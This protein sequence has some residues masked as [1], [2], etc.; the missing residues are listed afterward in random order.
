M[1]LW[2]ASLHIV[3]LI[4]S[5]NHIARGCEV[6][7]ALVNEDGTLGTLGVP[8]KQCSA[9]ATALTTFFK[10]GAELA[11]F[12]LPEAEFTCTEQNSTR[13][14]ACVG[15]VEQGDVEPMADYFWQ[16]GAMF[17]KAVGNMLGLGPVPCQDVGCVAEKHIRVYSPCLAPLDEHTRYPLVPDCPSV[18]PCPSPSPSPTSSP[19]PAPDQRPPQQVQ[20]QPAPAAS[21]SSTQPTGQQPAGQQSAAGS[22][23]PAA[24]KPSTADGSGGVPQPGQGPQGQGQASSGMGA[25]S[26]VGA[27][28]QGTVPPPSG[29]SSKK[30][31][32]QRKHASPPPRKIRTGIR[33]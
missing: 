5:L 16:T 31:P 7:V 22:P 18:G 27:Q 9:L 26:G 11:G 10:Q 19:A 32:P 1:Q 17:D 15:G 8:D 23:A 20:P 14:V 4:L 33:N 6:C 21:P 30:P 25:G 13:Q 29:R 28:N 24:P 2:K 12:S 3:V